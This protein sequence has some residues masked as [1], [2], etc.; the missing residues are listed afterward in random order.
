MNHATHKYSQDWSTSGFIIS[1]GLAAAVAF[2]GYHAIATKQGFDSEDRT[3]PIV[4]NDPKAKKLDPKKLV[5]AQKHELAWRP[6]SQDALNR[7]LVAARLDRQRV[8]E[9]KVADAMR[10]FAWRTAPGQLNLITIALEQGKFD[11]VFQHAD[12]LSRREKATEEVFGLFALYEQMPKQREYLVA[13]LKKSPPW[14]QAFLASAERLKS[15]QQVNARYETIAALLGTGTVQRDELSSLLGRMVATGSAPQAYDLWVKTQRPTVK[16]DGLFDGG[17][18]QA[19]DLQKS[20]ISNRFP[21]EWQFDSGRNAGTQLVERDSGNELQLY[22]NGQGVPIF[23]KQTVRARPA[24]YEVTLRGVEADKI[25]RKVVAVELLCPGQPAIR[26]GPVAA[27]AQNDL[28]FSADRA[29]RC[30]YPEIRLFG[31]PDINGA[32]FE[33]SLTGIS[34]A[35]SN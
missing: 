4:F 22:W 32:D 29:T 20:A 6:L 12:A 8:L 18:E 35:V 27:A 2:T 3:A 23:A 13:A 11:Q 28:S 26:L 21:F 17:F 5:A 34:L 14:R 33:M 30:T 10:G 1:V 31:R 16:P 19:V 24:V 9:K 7:L 25:A 15:P